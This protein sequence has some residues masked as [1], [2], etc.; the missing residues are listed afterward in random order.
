MNKKTRVLTLS[1]LLAALSLIFLY[2]ASIWPTGR[3]GF[4]AVSSLFAAAA[5]CDVGVIHGFYVY[6]VC[7]A[8]GLLFIPERSATF[9]YIL[10]FGYY[11][12]VKYL[13]ERIRTKLLQWALKLLVFN[14]AL[15]ILW[16]ILKTLVF[17][18]G[19]YSP[20]T[21]VVYAGCNVIF[22]VFDYGYSKLIRFY[23]ERISVFIRKR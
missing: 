8:L 2:F 1:A 16:L 7:S 19:G 20:G 9:L 12:A 23:T 11:P 14:L 21:P 10:F 6:L 17:D 13:I 5:V 22:I 18:M 3:F 15:T 4:V